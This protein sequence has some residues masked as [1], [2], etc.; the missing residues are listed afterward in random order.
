MLS[1]Y[2]RAKLAEDKFYIGKC[3]KHGMTE[4]YTSNRK[5]AECSRERYAKIREERGKRERPISPIVSLICESCGTVF[6]RY[7]SDLSRPGQG[8]F[9]GLPCKHV[10]HRGNQYARK[11]SKRPEKVYNMQVIN[12]WLV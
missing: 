5:C 9:C 11:H 12:G 7:A 1:P 8:R 3:R 2:E 6:T 4:M 10:G